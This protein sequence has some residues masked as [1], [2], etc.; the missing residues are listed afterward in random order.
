MEASVQWHFPVVSQD[1]VKWLDLLSEAAEVRAER[2]STGHVLF[3]RPGDSQHVSQTVKEAESMGYRIV[4]TDT[5]MLLRC[6]YS[7]PFAY[8]L[9]EQDMQVEAIVM[10][11]TVQFEGTSIPVEISMACTKTEPVLDDHHIVTSFPL[12]LSPLVQGWFGNGGMRIG[13]GGRMLSECEMHEGGYEATLKDQTVNI[14][15]PSEAQG[16]QIKSGVIK[17]LFAQLWSV[18]LFYMHHWED[19]I[20]LHTQHRSFRF[21]RTPYVPQMPTLINDTVSSTSMFSV[22]LGVFAADVSLQSVTVGSDTVTWKEALHQGLHLTLLPFSNGSHAYALQVP[23]SHRL[24]TQKVINGQYRRH[25]LPLTFDF[26]ILPAEEHYSY[27]A[28]VVCDLKES[29]EHLMYFVTCTSCHVF[30]FILK[31]LIF[32]KLSAFW[33]HFGFS[34]YVQWELYVGQRRLDWELVRLG[35]YRL[36]SSDDHLSVEMPLYSPGMTYEEFSLKE[37]V[38]KVEFSAV[39]VVTLK[40]EHSLV[41]RCM[42]PVRD[43]LVC[44]PEGRMVVVADTTRSVPPTRPNST[45]LL[46]PSCTPVATDSTRALFNFSLDSCGTTVTVEGNYLLYENQI[47][48]TQKLLP[49][50]AP[51]IHTDSPYRLT[52]QCRYPV[53]ETR[54]LTVHPLHN[55]TIKGQWTLPW[56]Q[57]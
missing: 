36:K 38:A 56:T 23:F 29:G 21:L 31:F 9:K 47:R 10:I 17:G 6:A 45:S 19:M 16:A 46:D 1:G 40:V 2:L 44:L 55:T 42:F 54:T 37:L 48:Y 51:I 12:T 11:I 3:Y 28:D 50:E 22:T 34:L 5:R 7:S 57:T 4:A 15:I 41:Q 20:W 14:R 39:D 26:I 35:D 18:D 33:Y 25:I 8:T 24:V 53:N 27:S 30:P 52:L 43:L 13:V 32:F 49:E